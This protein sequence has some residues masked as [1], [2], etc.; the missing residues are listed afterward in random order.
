MRR[1]S[2]LFGVMGVALATPSF[3]QTPAISGELE[4]SST[5]SPKEKTQFADGA[6]AEIDGAVKTV[7]GL[8]ADAEK[9]KNVE[10]IEC[11]TRKLTPMRAL[12]E[13][14]KQSNTTMRQSL[15]ANDAVHADQEFRK[16][17][18][19][20]TK[21][22]EF[23]AEAQACTGDAGVERGDSSSTVTDN[24]DNE[25]DADVDIPDILDPPGESGGT[26]Q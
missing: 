19:A 6:L 15:A 7:E 4:Q 22:R 21:A 3:A 12:L 26:P 14:S 9:E 24:N 25:I 5:T 18:V 10:E 13:V 2:F 1:L 20:L 8:L 11:L 23:L 16:V 17:A